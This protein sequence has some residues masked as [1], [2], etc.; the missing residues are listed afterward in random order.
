MG[1]TLV[2]SVTATL[3]DA[4]TRDSY[5]RWLREGHLAAVVAGGAL[6]AELIL[7]DNE[8]PADPL[9]VRSSYLFPSREAFENYVREH[10][11]ALRAEGLKRFPPERGISFER[12]IGVVDFALGPSGQPGKGW[13]QLSEAL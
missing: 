4:Q 5:V 13:T 9:R 1:P 11:A 12:T 2:Y 6:R 10:S 7:L 8:G 3:P